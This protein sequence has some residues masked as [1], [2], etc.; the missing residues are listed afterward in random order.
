MLK[1]KKYLK[2]QNMKFEI[3]KDVPLPTNSYRILNWP[4]ADMKPGDSVVIPASLAKKGKAAAWQRQ[5]RYDESF[6]TRA[7]PNGDVRIWRI[8]DKD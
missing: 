1:R 7:L 6:V 5:S 2:A 8:K 3:E 4:F